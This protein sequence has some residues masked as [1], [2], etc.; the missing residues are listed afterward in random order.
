MRGVAVASRPQVTFGQMA[1]TVPEIMDG[2]L[3]IPDAW[4][5]LASTINWFKVC[6]RM[7][8]S[9]I[10]YLPVFSTHLLLFF[11][12]FFIEWRYCK[13][14]CTGSRVWLGLSARAK[15][16]RRETCI[17]SCECLLS[18]SDTFICNFLSDTFI[19]FTAE[20]PTGARMFCTPQHPG[21]L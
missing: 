7:F 15:S 1:A 5:F 21:L 16:E 18:C 17:F 13:A 12:F 14:F 10:F 11:F 19:V 6:V 8:V 20:I 9:Q 4:Q 3:Y 2:S